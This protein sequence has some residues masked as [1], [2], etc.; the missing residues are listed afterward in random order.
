MARYSAESGT[1][2]KSSTQ[3]GVVVVR[4]AKTGMHKVDKQHRRSSLAGTPG[5]SGTRFCST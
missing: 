4:S 3:R 1:F 2:G 5:V